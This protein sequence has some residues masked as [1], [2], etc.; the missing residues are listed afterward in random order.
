LTRRARRNHSP[1]FKAK[2]AIA[3]IQGT[4][5]ISELAKRF[6]VHPN[7]ITQW[8]TQLLDSAAAVFGSISKADESPDV[9]VLHAK[10]GQLTLEND[11]LEKALGRVG[12]PS[13]RR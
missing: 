6:D 9:Q 5:T 4:L 2:V 7:Q 12:G 11:F 13:V 8:K 3:A 10:I 1:A